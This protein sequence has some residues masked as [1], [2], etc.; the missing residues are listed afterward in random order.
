LME[1][2]RLRQDRSRQTVAHTSS[3]AVYG[4]AFAKQRKIACWQL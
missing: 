3:V 4:D 2:K 1:T